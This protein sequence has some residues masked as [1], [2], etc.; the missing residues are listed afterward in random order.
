MC[1]KTVVKAKT[2]TKDKS[3][4]GEGKG[5][6]KRAHEEE[7]NERQHLREMM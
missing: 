1:Q 7:S 6:Q 2:Q 4:G 3:T 5:D